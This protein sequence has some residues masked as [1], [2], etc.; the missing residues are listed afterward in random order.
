ME[1]HAYCFCV[2]HTVK[3][4][5]KPGSL[6]WGRGSH[7]E[8]TNLSQTFAF[9]SH[10]GHVVVSHDLGI[11]GHNDFTVLLAANS[12]PSVHLNLWSLQIQPAKK[13]QPGCL[14][15]GWAEPSGH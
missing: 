9:I 4:Q 3:E 12:E 6:A 8:V 13:N 11:W 15:S 1:N 2:P 7:L 14:L 5:K 10:L